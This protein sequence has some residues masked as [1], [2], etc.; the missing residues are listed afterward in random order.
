MLL[1][2]LFLV[3]SPFFLFHFCAHGRPGTL[4]KK[5]HDSYMILSIFAYNNNNVII[6]IIKITII[7]TRGMGWG[8]KRKRKKENSN[9]DK[10]FGFCL[11]FCKH[12]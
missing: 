5:L 1:K 12:D 11:T 4:A 6:I 8:V 3:F 2:N 10:F 9:N 7:I